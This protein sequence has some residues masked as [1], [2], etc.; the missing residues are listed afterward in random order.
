M[1]KLSW[2]S[3]FREGDGCDGYTLNNQR[4]WDGVHERKEDAS[5]SQVLA[6]CPDRGGDGLF[7][8]RMH[9]PHRVLA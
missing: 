7:P 2:L 9:R 8:E 5:K 4:V 3:D 1:V 6:G